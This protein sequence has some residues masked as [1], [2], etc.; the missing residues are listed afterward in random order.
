MLR[1]NAQETSPRIETK[2][3][4]KMSATEDRAQQMRTIRPICVIREL[5]VSVARGRGLDPAPHALGVRLR[6]PQTLDLA[7]VGVPRPTSR[8]PAW[9]VRCLRR[10]R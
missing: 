7:A 1:S 2:K 5:E 4:Q 10:E 9:T 6:D 3:S 8:P